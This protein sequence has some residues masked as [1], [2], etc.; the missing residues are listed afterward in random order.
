[1]SN[2]V[3]LLLVGCAYVVLVGG[4]SLLRREGLSLRLAV[5]AALIILLAIGLVVVTGLV[6][7]PVLFLLFLYVV[8][9]RVRILVDQALPAGQHVVTWDGTDDRG[10]GLGSGVY[11]VRLAAGTSTIARK[12][13]LVR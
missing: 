13:L 8:T 2:A 12:A 3:L 4:L 7:H 5:E 10:V 9:M 11:V 1:M 6:I